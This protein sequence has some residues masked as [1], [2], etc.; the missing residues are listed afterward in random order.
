MAKG[1]HISYTP[2]ANLSF[3][4]DELDKRY[5]LCLSNL[6][7]NIQHVQQRETNIK[8]WKQGYALHTMQTGN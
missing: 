7:K 8:T 2:Y 3:V 4:T 1:L 5:K 6:G